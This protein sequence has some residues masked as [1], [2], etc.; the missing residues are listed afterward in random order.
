MHS[1]IKIWDFLNT[2][3]NGLPQAG[4]ILAIYCYDSYALKFIRNKF[5]SDKFY[6]QKLNILLSHELSKEWIDNNFHSMGLF[7]NNESY[8][9][10]GAEEMS[11]DVISYL[12][13]PEELIL[14]GR[15]LILN[16]NKDNK[17][18]KR[19]QKDQSG[20]IDTLQIMAPAFWEEKR[21]L[22]FMISEMNIS[23]SGDVSEFILQSVPADIAS[24]G[25]ILEQLV[26]NTPQSKVINNLDLITSLVDPAKIDQF[27]LLELFATKKLQTFYKKLLMIIASGGEL[28]PLLYSLQGHF[29]KIYDHSYLEQKKK[30]TKYDLSIQYQSSLWTQKDLAKVI[31]YFSELLILAK[32]KSSSLEQKIKQDQLRLVRF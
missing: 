6:E 5:P 15:Y 25:H 13:R 11:D 12:S 1:K 29:L 18:F 2:Y 4:R 23:L 14:T 9:I 26:L 31:D 24:Y 3:P 20:L 32:K 10:H 28:V 8:F 27:E 30:L 19:L 16:F 22:D 7:G 21:L 17:N